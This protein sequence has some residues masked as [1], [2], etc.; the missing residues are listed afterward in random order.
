MSTRKGMVKGATTLGAGRMAINIASLAS[1]VVLARLLTPEDFGIVAIATAALGIMMALTEFSLGAALVRHTEATRDLIDTAWTLMLIRTGLIA[2]VFC[3]AAWPLARLYGDPRL[4]WVLV[5]TGVAGAMSGFYAPHVSLMARDLDFRPLVI[6]QLT[7]RFAGFIIAIAIA[8]VMRSYWAIII[9]NAAGALAASAMSYVLAPYRPR[10]TLSRSRD[11][12]G[13]SFWLFASE[14]VNVLNWRFDQ[15]LI[16]A[17][18]PKAQLGTYSVADNISALPSRESTAPLVQ[19]LFPALVKLKDNR[20]RLSRRYMTAQTAIGLVALPAGFG[21]AVIADPFVRLALGEKW[22]AAIPVIQILACSLAVQT[23]VVGV[24]PL[25][26]ALDMTK[27][28][29]LRNIMGLVVRIACVVPGLFYWGLQGLVWGRAISTML[30]LVVA[31]EWV[32]RLTGVGVVRQFL[33]H[34]RTF[35]AVAAMAATGLALQSALH[36]E[37]MSHPALL[38][39]ATVPVAALAYLT[40]LLLLWLIAGKPSGAE[41][42]LFQ[43]AR[44]IIL[45][46]RSRIQ[47]GPARA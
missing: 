20:E 2:L 39:A 22:L 43:I 34:A 21:L 40:A 25:A 1:T 11:L 17:V 28:L 41:T 18:L 47:A 37:G 32:K 23:L 10:L 6:M 7:Q 13:F 27:V 30:G 45:D 14:V 5:V 31:Y 15:L 38:I 33:H 3:L 35:G 26:M 4:G 29:F 19:P 24:R 16:G 12:V 9:G 46:L 42:E 44:Q 36:A 8:L